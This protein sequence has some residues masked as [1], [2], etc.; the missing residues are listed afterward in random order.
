MFKV[1]E[2]G[3][4]IE[5]NNVRFRIYLPSIDED[6]GFSVKVYVINKIDQFDVNVPA[7]V[8]SLAPEPA[9]P[10]NDAE[11]G[12]VAKTRWCSGL[13]SMDPGTYLYRFEI[14]G[15]ERES[16]DKVRSLYFGDP[17][18]RETDAGIFSVFRIPAETPPPWED[19]TFK[20]PPLD[21][22]ILYE[23]NVAEFGGTFAGVADR[24]PYLKSLGVNAIELLPINSI[25]EPTQ[26]GYMPIFYFAP[27]ERFGGPAGLQHLVLECHRNGIA[28]VLDMVY[29]HTDRMFPYQIGYERFFHLWYDDYFTG[30][31][32]LHRSPNPLVCSYDNFGKKND[33]RM[34]ST[35]QFFVAVN[36]FW[37]REYHIDGFRYDHVNGY[38]DRKP[39]L[40]NGKI[41]WYSHENRPTFKS[42]QELSKATYQESKSHPRF[43]SAPNSPSRILQIAEDLGES[44]YQ[45][46]PLSASAIN[47][48]WEK[49]L[50]DIAKNMAINDALSADMGIELLL[51]DHRFD[52]QGYIGRKTVED[53]T[54]PAQVVQFIESHDE[55]RLFYLMQN[56]KALGDSGYEYRNGLD[57]QPWW[58]LQPYA[59]A[60]MTSV[61]IPMIWAGQEFAEN[62]G[63]AES[64][65]VR[66]RGFRPLHWDYF[67]NVAA[68]TD[69]AT[70]LP[71]VTLYRKLG[72]LRRKHLALRAPRGNAKEEYGSQ[73]ERVLVYRRWAADDILI[74]ALNFSDSERYVPIPFG[75]AGIWVDVLEA[76][77]RNPQGPYSKLVTD[78]AAHE[79]VPI[80]SNFGRILRLES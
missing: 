36:A 80:P 62:S 13:I 16:G 38:L 30:A 17:C 21:E 52:D 47:G 57:G 75:H 77:Y 20:V 72:N 12:D 45:L 6:R 28:V 4:K 9:N 2:T 60:L 51:A 46:S 66:V 11:W 41:E 48:C 1:E 59:I 49:R 31:N 5:D 78:P 64:G 26:W 15:P 74:I 34:Q 67:Y 33:W 37:L 10:A 42:L 40:N 73:E 58:K 32:G 43:M 7:K 55:C 27:E 68:S 23:L 50:A 69:G 29:A 14:S 35:Q 79:W 8:Y 44:A 63:L 39:I 25:V 54:I 61:G 22:I 76:S 65:M 24:I 56:G 70:V 53:D 71:L 18:A 3:P 19:G